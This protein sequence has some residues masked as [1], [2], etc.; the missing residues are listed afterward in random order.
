M[1]NNTYI[2]SV[3]DLF[4]VEA[5]DEEAAEQ[6]LAERLGEEPYVPYDIRVIEQED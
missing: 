2:L 4:R 6:K 3:E 1:S 5:E